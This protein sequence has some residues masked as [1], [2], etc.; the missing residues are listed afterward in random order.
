[1][2]RHSPGTKSRA[3]LSTYCVLGSELDSGEMGQPGP[4]PPSELG[5]GLGVE[6]IIAGTLWALELAQPLCPGKQV[7]LERPPLML[8]LPVP[9]QV[10]RC[11]PGAGGERAGV[12]GCPVCCAEQ[13]PP[14]PRPRGL[15][16]LCRPPGTP[17]TPQPGLQAVGRVHADPCQGTFKDPS[18][19]YQPLGKTRLCQSLGWTSGKTLLPS[20]SL[21]VLLWA[22]TP[23]FQML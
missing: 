3:Y 2:A 1:M 7:S 15:L 17:D 23:S 11:Q 13:G 14:Q 20:W 4:P 19:A 9:S 8:L 6:E 22:V 10:A 18:P 16:C 5:Q 21:S 12:R